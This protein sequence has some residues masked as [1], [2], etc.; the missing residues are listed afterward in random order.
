MSE[1]ELLQF[2]S[3]KMFYAV[4]C[5]LVVGI[6]RKINHA[7][8]GFKTQILV[9]VGSMLFTCIPAIAGPI[10]VH[11]TARVIAQI[12]TGV[13]FLGAGAIMHKG[14]HRSVVGLTTAAWIWFTAAIGILIGIEH[15]PVALFITTTLVAVISFARFFERKFFGSNH[16]AHVEHLPRKE[17]ADDD[18]RKAG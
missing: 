8:A 6:E 10:M 5:G 1:L 15:G 11:E 4:I 17:K 9:C 14:E 7:P 2:I 16:D 12:I 3:L 18:I 13:G